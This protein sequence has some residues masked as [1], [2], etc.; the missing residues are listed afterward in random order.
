MEVV[1]LSNSATMVPRNLRCLL[2]GASESG[3]SSFILKLLK[4]KG[5]MFPVCYSKFI[6][7]SPHIGSNGY[8]SNRD[9]EY[10]KLL[11]EYCAPAEILFF[12]YILTEEELLQISESVDGPVLFI[13]DDFA[14]QLFQSDLI[15]QLYTQMSS[16]CRV[17]SI[18]SLHQGIS[19]KTSGKW[20]QAVSQNSNYIVVFRNLAN[21]S[22]LG[23]L[24][25]RIF[26]YAD[27]YLSRALTRAVEVL[28]PYGYIVIDASLTNE[29]NSKFG[30]RS[31]VFLEQNLPLLLF[32]LLK[33][34][35][36]GK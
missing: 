16:H 2:Q 3:K 32:K 35:Y 17:N 12:N 33:I 4:N 20:Y 1:E 34:Y 26:P 9:L 30:V 7:C 24:S 21:R 14:L 22:C 10:R 18:V 36:S 31:N 8:S 15:Y 29:L 25:K 11:E 23:E 27:N 5:S 6:Y 28:G 19:G 13:C